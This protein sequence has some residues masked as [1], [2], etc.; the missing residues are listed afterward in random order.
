MGIPGEGTETLGGAPP[1]RMR[2]KRSRSRRCDGGAQEKTGGFTG[3]RVAGRHG[4]GL[5]PEGQTCPVCICRGHADSLGV[6]RADRE[7]AQTLGL[8]SEC[9]APAGSRT[10]DKQ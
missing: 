4:T 5:C 6:I 1:A 9:L 2:R 3:S 10:R 7:E 8:S